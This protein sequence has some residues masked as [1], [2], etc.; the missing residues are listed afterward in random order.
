M[1]KYTFVFWSA[2]FTLCIGL[3][4]AYTLKTKRYEAQFPLTT[5]GL[6]I[7][8]NRDDCDYYLD[9]GPTH[10]AVHCIK[11]RAFKFG[12][13]GIDTELAVCGKNGV[14]CLH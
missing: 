1:R 14:K 12:P 8:K 13:N 7:L 11:K 9:I 5:T 10:T 6:P 3:I 4:F 2:L